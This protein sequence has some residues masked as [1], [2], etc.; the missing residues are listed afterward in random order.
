MA[1]S[2][3][4]VA[5][6]VS[7]HNDY[8][9]KIISGVSRYA[10][11]IGNWTIFCE[12]E[13][14]HHMPSLSRWHGDGVIAQLENPAIHQ[15]VA[16]LKIPVVG[17]ASVAD[18]SPVLD[19]T[20]CVSIDNQQIG[21][22]GAAHLLEC[23]FESFAYCG[24]PAT[25]LNGWVQERGAAF[26]AAVTHAGYRLATYTGRHRTVRQW[27]TL[28]THM[29]AWLR[30]LKLPIGIMACDDPRARHVLETCRRLGLRVPEDVAVLGV[31]N[32]ELICELCHPP[33]TSIDTGIREVGYE[34][35]AALD[36]LMAGK[37]AEPVRTR[38]PPGKLVARRSTDILT[39]P[40]AGV[41]AALTFI[42]D[43]AAQPIQVSDVS[44]HVGV[45][46]STLDKHF[47]QVIGRTAHDEI[48]R[49]RLNMARSLLENTDWPLRVIA[50]K[51][52]YRNEQYMCK[53]L[54]LALGRT[55]GQHR[56]ISR[57]NRS[58]DGK[59]AARAVDG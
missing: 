27:E 4:R 26:S 59:Q 11:E 31:D 14:L 18:L 47:R 42:R 39:V 36:R 40:D 25:P 34:A 58:V 33:L 2:T 13:H 46:R 21:E 10:R 54:R 48:E 17:V 28:Q 37:R 5:L 41:A 6:L 23:G 50:Q 24:I 3:R 12:D 22:R 7:T 38:V 44:R 53:V 51:S 16:R 45:S 20:V 56:Q 9:R 43:H 1:R 8:D 57:M 55:P 29:A 52:G 32:D 49:V 35:A 19:Q 15:S 30:S